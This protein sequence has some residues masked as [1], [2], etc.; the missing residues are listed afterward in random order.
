M[1]EKTRQQQQQNGMSHSAQPFAKPQQQ[2]QVVP[3]RYHNAHQEDDYGFASGGA[4]AAPPAMSPPHA[5][6][7]KCYRCQRKLTAI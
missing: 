6:N 7:C 2:M 3:G 1:E 4:T 5:G